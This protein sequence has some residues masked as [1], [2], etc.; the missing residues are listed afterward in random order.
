LLS[1][2]IRPVNRSAARSSRSMSSG[3]SE[4]R[5][6]QDL[7]HLALHVLGQVPRVGARIGDQLGLVQRLRGLQRRGGRQS[8]TAVHV[9]LQF[10]QIVQLRRLRPFAAL[11]ILVTASG[12]PRTRSSMRCASA[13]SAKRSPA[14]LNCVSRYSGQQFPKRFG[15]ERADLVVARTIIASTGVCTRPT[16]HSIRGRRSGR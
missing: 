4:R 9:A 14:N 7:R 12:W 15:A 13:S 1:L 3:R 10:G 5:L 8:E 6:F 16:L 2:T 11:S